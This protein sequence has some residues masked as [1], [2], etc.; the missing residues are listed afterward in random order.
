[1]AETIWV[2]RL[3]IS[4]AVA[5][6]LS[7]KHGLQAVEVRD[8]VQGVRGLPFRW[9]EHPERGRRAIVETAIRGRKVAIVL[10][11]AN[12]P[13]GDTYDLGSAYRIP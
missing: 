9:D 12:D 13:L 10:Y 7:T 4:R 6:K 3:R 1:M 2:A 11:P 8:A 5:H